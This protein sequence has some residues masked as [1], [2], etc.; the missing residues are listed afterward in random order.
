MTTNGRTAISVRSLIIPERYVSSITYT[1]AGCDAPC[2]TARW[3]IITIIELPAACRYD[4]VRGHLFQAQA[5]RAGA[6]TPSALLLSI[7]H[8]EPLGDHQ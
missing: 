2:G 6:Q 4:F 8:G 5:R 7:A 3:C 1:R